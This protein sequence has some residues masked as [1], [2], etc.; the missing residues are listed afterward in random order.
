MTFSENLEK[1]KQQRNRSLVDKKA[2]ILCFEDGNNFSDFK[3]VRENTK[4]IVNFYLRPGEGHRKTCHKIAGCS[5]SRPVI[6]PV[7]SLHRHCWRH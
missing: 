1:F 3:I 4:Y 5:K 2:G 7:N 6:S